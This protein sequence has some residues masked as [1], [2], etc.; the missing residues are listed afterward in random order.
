MLEMLQPAAA[1]AVDEALAQVEAL[2]PPDELASDHQLLI[3]YLEDLRDVVRDVPL[4][5]GE[6]N[7]IMM[8][9]RLN[10]VRLVYCDAR[11][12]FSPAIKPIVDGHFADPRE[13][14]CGGEPF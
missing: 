10:R 4:V 3:K 7:M 2:K 13:E 8:L 14:F 6:V 11:A 5:T 1:E 9:E 12:A